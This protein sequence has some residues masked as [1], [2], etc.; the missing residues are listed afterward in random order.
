MIPNYSTSTVHNLGVIFDESLTV[1]LENR[2]QNRTQSFMYHN[3][4]YD[5][6]TRIYLK[7]PNPGQPME[8][9]PFPLLWNSRPNNLRIWDSLKSFNSKLRTFLLERS[10][11]SIT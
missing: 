4:T 3:A 5:H 10:Y 1:N 9:G 2:P 8:V 7:F 11:L 6:L